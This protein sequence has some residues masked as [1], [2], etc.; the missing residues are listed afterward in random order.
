MNTIQPNIKLT[1]D[2]SQTLLHPI[3]G[4]FYHSTRGAV[5]EAIHIFIE[6]GLKATAKYNPAILEVGFGSGLNAYLTM[7][8][9]ERSGRTVEYTTIE[10]YPIAME[11][12]AQLAYADDPLFIAIH[13]VEWNVNVRIT[14]HFSIKKI[15]ADLD[16]TI[17]DTTFDLIYFDAFAPES[18]PEMWSSKVFAHL[19]A[20]MNPGATLV[21]YSAKGVVKQTLREVG[22]EVRRLPGALGKR[23]MIRAT[24][25]DE[26]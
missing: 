4:E 9:A 19:Y 14:E 18:Q 3:I 17:F 11:T 13:N 10:R 20:R 21:T 22:F 26:L 2:G 25:T 23:H 24:K 1:D 7:Q 5:G 6:N 12:V 15:E 8:E 16:N